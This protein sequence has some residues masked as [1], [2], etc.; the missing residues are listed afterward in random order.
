MN[1]RQDGNGLKGRIMDYVPLH[2]KEFAH[3]EGKA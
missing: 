1:R 3:L 2:S